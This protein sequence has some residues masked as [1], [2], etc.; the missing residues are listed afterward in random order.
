MYQNDKLDAMH[1]C[2]YVVWTEFNFR[3]SVN[4]LDKVKLLFGKM[5]KQFQKATTNYI[6][7]KVSYRFVD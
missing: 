4:W 6:K 2:L 1:N 3:S 5:R 7:K